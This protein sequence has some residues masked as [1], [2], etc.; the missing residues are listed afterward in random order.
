MEPSETMPEPVL[1][2]QDLSRKINEHRSQLDQLRQEY[3]TRQ[4]K[5]AELTQQQ[6][7]LRAQ[8]RQ[9]DAQIKAVKEGGPASEPASA[10]VPSPAQSEERPTLGGLL[11]EV[12]SAAAGPVTVAQLAKEVKRRKFPTKSK[13][14][15]RLVA[16]RVKELVEKGIFR[17]A[18]GQ[19]GVVATGQ[20]GSVTTTAPKPPTRRGHAKAATAAGK[21]SPQGDNGKAAS[22]GSRSSLRAVLAK[23]LG[24][25]KRPMAARE[26]AEQALAGGYH[27]ESKNLT[28]AVWTA[29]G[30]TDNVE[31]VPGKG[32]RLKR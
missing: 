1:P 29:L 20:S 2:L 24:K 31:N 5:L 11:M 3:E 16:T 27:T 7:A 25:S 28:N 18:S 23:L 21:S 9:V 15:P 6:Q 14:I 22:T 12:V 10:P 26:L 30:R 8:L 19:P 17:R 32:Y 4:A 13:D